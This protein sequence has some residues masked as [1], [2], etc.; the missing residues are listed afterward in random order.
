MATGCAT[1]SV[2][3]MTIRYVDITCGDD[4]HPL[5]GHH[6]GMTAIRYVDTTCGDDGHPLCGHHVWE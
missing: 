1:T 2:G 5:C 3:M 4:D 6:V